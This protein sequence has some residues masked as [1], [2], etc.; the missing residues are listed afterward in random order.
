M[1]IGREY[2]NIRYST[3]T[4]NTLASSTTSALGSMTSLS[5]RSSSSHFPVSSSNSV[6]LRGEQKK[7]PRSVSDIPLPR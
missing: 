6:I 2:T 3:D 4:G 7:S 5:S 1:Q